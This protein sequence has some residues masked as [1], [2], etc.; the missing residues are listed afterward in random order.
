MRIAVPDGAQHVWR[1]LWSGDV[2]ACKAARKAADAAWEET[3][4]DLKLLSDALQ[5]IVNPVSRKTSSVKPSAVLTKVESL[6][7]KEKEMVEKV[8]QK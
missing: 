4:K 8:Q 2:A 5:S 3:A 6:V 1:L 7:Q